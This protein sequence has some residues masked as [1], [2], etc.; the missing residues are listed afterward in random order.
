MWISDTSVVSVV[1]SRSVDLQSLMKEFGQRQSCS[2][3]ITS[4]SLLPLI[5]PAFFTLSHSLPSPVPLSSPSLT[6]SFFL[7]LWHH[8]VWD[9]VEVLVLSSRWQPW[10]MG[11]AFF[12]ERM[13]LQYQDEVILLKNTLCILI[14]SFKSWNF[15][16]LKAIY[17][18]VWL[19]C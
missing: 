6:L 17:N 13:H 8:L 3:N 11:W 4:P 15:Q 1:V 2:E 9:V 10:L 16:S 14:H 18:L 5:S 7:K 12:V 19:L